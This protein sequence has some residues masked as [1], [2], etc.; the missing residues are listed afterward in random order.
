MMMFY[1]PR[2]RDALVMLIALL[3]GVLTFV[4]SGR[5]GHEWAKL[6]ATFGGF[7]LISFAVFFAIRPDDVRSAVNTL[8]VMT[9]LFAGSALA[10]WIVAVRVSF[11]VEH[12]KVFLMALV[13]VI[14]GGLLFEELRGKITGRK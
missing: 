12:L 8:L 9:A 10:I 6:L 11:G 14:L 4:A 1:W 7:S 3:L 2:K 5:I 13:A